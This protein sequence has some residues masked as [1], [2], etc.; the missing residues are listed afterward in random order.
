MRR[1]FGI[2]TEYGITCAA[3]LGH[4]PIDAEQAARR[5]FNPVVNRHR[6]SN[7]FL[8]NGGRL[9]LDVGSHPEYATAECDYLADLLA[10]D[11]A[12]QEIFSDLLV[13]T[14]RQLQADGINGQIHLFKNNRD[15]QG[16]SCGCH[17]NYLLHRSADF[18]GMADALITF[19]I[20]RQILVGAGLIDKEGGYHFSQRADKIYDPISAATTRVRPIINTRDEPLANSD[21]YRRMHVI[22]GDSNICEATTALKV[23]M[24]IALLDAIDC[25][26]NLT[27][28]AI[29][30]PMNAIRKIN[31]DLSGRASLKLKV[32]GYLD[33]VEIQNRIFQRVMNTLGDAGELETTRER[34]KVGDFDPLELWERMLRCFQ[35]E[36]FQAVNTEIDWVIK[37]NLLEQTAKRHQ[38]SMNSAAISR[39]DLAYHDI[40]AAGLAPALRQAGMMRK[41]LTCEEIATAKT[42]PP[43]TTRANMRGMILREAE[44][45]RRDVSVDW[46]HVRIDKSIMP[47]VM[48]GDPFANEGEILDKLLVELQERA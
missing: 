31:A 6:S 43:R 38:L 41:L 3:P 22:V 20:T 13:T 27:D 18:M 25:S 2:E 12:G 48:L 47:T 32:G 40:S 19:F 23:G 16:N 1:I 36:D 15:S 35:K 34:V 44:R 46:L 37:K 4:P 33:A 45:L 7:V 24:T 11:V 42:Y 17:E 29:A 26:L 30:D 8:G 39:L 5:L 28:L 10:Q 14:N 21:Q 9:Y